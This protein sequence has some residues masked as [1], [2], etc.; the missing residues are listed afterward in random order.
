MSLNLQIFKNE[1]FGEVRWL[2]IE[3][4]VYAVG[5]DIAKSLGYKDPNSAIKRHCKGSVKRLVPTNSGEQLMNCIAEG[6][7]YRLAAKSELPGADKFESWIFDEVLPTIRKTGGYVNNDDLFVN[8]YLKFADDGT[9]LMFKQT[10]ETV[11]KQNELIIEQQKSIE[12][13]EGVIIALVDK[14]TLA[15][16]RQ[17]LNRVVRYKGANF[18]E[19]WRELYRQFE[20]KYHIDLTRR[21]EAYNLSNKPKMKS[22]IDY[23]DKVM[24]KVSELYEIAC[25]LYENDVKELARN[26]YDI[27]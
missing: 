11:R 15:E 13:K 26:L 9:K 22:K 19:R 23:I 5:I 18:Q 24:D 17:I 10:L 21:F 12:H 27:A 1:Q 6:D 2:E 14:V 4:K 20:M 7:I 3:N 25:K 16:K 8:T